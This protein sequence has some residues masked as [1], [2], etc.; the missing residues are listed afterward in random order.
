VDVDVD[1]FIS[2]VQ[3]NYG[4]CQNVKRILLTS[5]DKCCDGWMIKA[6]FTDRNR[7]PSKNTRGAPPGHTQDSLGLDAQHLFHDH[8]AP[9]SSGGSFV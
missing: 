9:S 4:H 3:G 2:M 8:A 6:M 5:L 7:H 1:E